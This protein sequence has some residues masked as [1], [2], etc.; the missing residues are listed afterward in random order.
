MLAMDIPKS[1]G[2][3]ISNS[4]TDEFITTIAEEC[5]RHAG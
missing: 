5:L 3:R 2:M 1:L 4:F